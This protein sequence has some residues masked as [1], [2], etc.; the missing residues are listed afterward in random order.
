VLGGF[1]ELKK[2]TISDPAEL[3]ALGL[4]GVGSFFGCGTSSEMVS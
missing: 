2:K 4:V 1:W 3:D